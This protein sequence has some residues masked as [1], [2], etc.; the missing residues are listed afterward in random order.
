MRIREGRTKIVTIETPEH[1]HNRGRTQSERM[2]LDAAD[3]A[4]VDE[5]E[6]K[7]SSSEVEAFRALLWEERR[8]A[9]VRGAAD[10]ALSRL[11]A[12]P[13]GLVRPS[14]RR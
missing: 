9:G 1:R 6:A 11:I 14:W 4:Y 5:L 13:V 3:Y 8:E 2:R 7:L 12:L 10:K